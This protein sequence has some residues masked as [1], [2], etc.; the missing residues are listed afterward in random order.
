M[1]SILPEELFGSWVE[2]GLVLASGGD[3]PVSD[4]DGLI[5]DPIAMEKR[6]PQADIR[7]LCFM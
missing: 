4:G 7:I 6:K 1:K 5:S 3:N 2:S